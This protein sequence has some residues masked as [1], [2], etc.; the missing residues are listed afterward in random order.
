MNSIPL[1]AIVGYGFVA[2]GG[3]MMLVAAFRTSVLWGLGCLFLPIV[4]LIFLFAH[5]SDAKK[6]FIVQVVGLVI[7]LIALGRSHGSF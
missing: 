4:G 3:I 7:L 6:G 5:W 1:L 2:V